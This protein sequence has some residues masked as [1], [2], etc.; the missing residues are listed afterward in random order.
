MNHDVATGSLT[1]NIE[2]MSFIECFCH[3]IDF[4]DLQSDALGLLASRR[5]DRPKQFSSNTFPLVMWMNNDHS[6]E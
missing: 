2:A 1:F 4:E 5:D 6:Y 3:I